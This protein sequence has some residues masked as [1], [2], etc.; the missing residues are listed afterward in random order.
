[1]PRFEINTRRLVNG[2]LSFLALA[3]II[4]LFFAYR[5]HAQHLIPHNVPVSIQHLPYYAFC[6]FYRMLA[7]YIIA[8]VFSIIYGMAAARGGL[9]ERILIPAIDIAQSV[10]VV[11]F[12]PAAVYFFVAL[13]HGS[14]LG[15][16]MAAVFLIFT[17]QAWNMALGVYE[18]VKTIPEDSK[19]AIESFGGRGWLRFKRL[20]LP[21]S[22]PK[23]VYNS[24]LS[25]VAGWYFLIACEIITVGPASYR[26]PGLGSFLWEASEKGRNFDLAAGLLTLLAIIV[27]MDMIVWQPLSTWAEKFKY[28]FAASSGAVQ[29][30]GMFDALSGVGPAVTRAL[31]AILVPPFRLVATALEA[32]PR[33]PKLSPEQS[34]RVAAIVRTLIISAIV[35]FITWALAR[36]LVAL[37]RTLSQ[38]WPSDARQIPEAIVLSTIR[39][40]I[41]YAISLAWTV[42]CALAASENPRF[43][44]ILSPV[45]EI[46][47][48]MPAT[49]LFP[50]IVA[51]FIQF[52]GGMNIASVVLILTG[53]QWYLL[54]N[55]L[56]GIN[57]VPED[58]KEASR[59][60]GLSR[61]ARWRK[62]ILP[63]VTPS[64]ITGSITGWGGGWN[65]LI[66]S[67]YFVY[68][69]QTHQVLGI[70]S[71]LDAATYK[72]GNGVMILL[73]L[74][75]M[76]AV[77]LLLN[78]L[79][80]R[81]LYN[82]AT[83]RY[84]LDY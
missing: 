59:A 53:M 17:S 22:I 74:L 84:R 60:F 40:T 57:Q 76:I 34:K 62:L 52:A 12:F 67:E 1:M 46:V 35:I 27:L 82:L 29:S 21:A 43:N 77:V 10:P 70:G 37:I 49:A 78:R 81:P 63:A 36:G 83:E 19:D 20:L 79:M 6:S 55:L 48:S 80:W 3:A 11:G 31:R 15:V 38:P 47:G 14:R 65:A 50:V 4:A 44:R 64:L 9:Y 72:S 56:A 54:F 7:A 24:I 42:P 69:N 58:L 39:M 33:S 71:L 75:S 41:A 25:W 51:A 8:L 66:L 61:I 18:A 5:S 26:L 30:L 28:E 45:A 32:L 68:N 16:E 23:L 73:S 13:A 2:S